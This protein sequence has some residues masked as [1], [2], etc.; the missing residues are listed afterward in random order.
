MVFEANRQTKSSVY[1]FWLRFFALVAVLVAAFLLFG[2]S[3]LFS[4]TDNS[5]PWNEESRILPPGKTATS[6][7]NEQQAQLTEILRYKAQLEQDGSPRGIVNLIVYPNGIVKG[8]WAGEY[9]RDE[10]TH[11]LVM[12]GSFAGNID[13]TKPYIENGVA[14]PTKLY[15]ITTG[16]FTMLETQISTG[17]NSSIYGL[18]YVC[19]WIDSDYTALAELTLTKNKK[20]LETF[21][22]TAT[23]IN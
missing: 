8:V 20:T 12:A 1:P 9:D 10:D 16:S 2:P 6:S 4:K 17:K 18:V 15:F 21:P 3:F 11:C 5:L 13:P 19:G 7:P 23:P 14:N 22:W